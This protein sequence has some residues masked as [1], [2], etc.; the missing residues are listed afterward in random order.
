MARTSRKTASLKQDIQLLGNVL[1]D[2]LRHQEGDNLFELVE[3][4]RTLSKAAR[5]G[6]VKSRKKLEALLE[7]LNVYDNATN[8]SAF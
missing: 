2:V 8:K 7:S 4:I 6:K 3:E 1:G 5:S